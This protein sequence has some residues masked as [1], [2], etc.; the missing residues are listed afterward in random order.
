MR[1]TAVLGLVTAFVLGTAGCS[2]GQ[3]PPASPTT[4]AS[5]ELLS[6]A[7]STNL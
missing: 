7:N 2:V 4:P 5:S 3:S 6:D 1:R